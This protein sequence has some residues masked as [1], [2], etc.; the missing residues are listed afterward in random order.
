MPDSSPRMISSKSLIERARAGDQEAWQELFDDCYPKI[1]RVIRRR[2]SRPLRTLYDSTDIANEVMQ[3]LAAKFDQVDFSSISGLRA[4][5]IHAAECKV[6]DGYRHCHAR[7][8]DVSRTQASFRDDNLDRFEVPDSGPTPSQIAVASESE[9]NLL[10]ERNSDER[11]V[12]EMKVR[13]YSN[14]EVSEATGW[15]LR[16]IERFLEKLRGTCRL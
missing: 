1:V 4:Y 13:G 15:H 10:R 12:I 7:K 9:A 16:K 8:R 6:V 3:S 2:I 11:S 5:L 14:P